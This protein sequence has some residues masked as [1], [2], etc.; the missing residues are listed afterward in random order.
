MLSVP[1]STGTWV[2]AWRKSFLRP[3]RTWLPLEQYEEVGVDSA[4]GEGKEGEEC[5]S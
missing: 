4:K 5:Y 3:V 1:L 2:R